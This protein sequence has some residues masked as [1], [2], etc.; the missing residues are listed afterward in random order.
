V[1]VRRAKPGAVDVAVVLAVG[2]LLEVVPQSSYTWANKLREGLALV[3]DL[4]YAGIVD[5][6]H[7]VAPSRTALVENLVP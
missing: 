4:A 1:T 3:A 7:V 2:L 6:A 5:V